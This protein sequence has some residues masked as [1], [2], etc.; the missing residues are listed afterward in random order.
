MLSQTFHAEPQARKK[1]SQN[2][3][4]ENPP[5]VDPQL[6]VVYLITVETVL[7]LPLMMRLCLAVWLF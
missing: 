4:F 5:P 1:I 7:C 6:G 3:P 2:Y